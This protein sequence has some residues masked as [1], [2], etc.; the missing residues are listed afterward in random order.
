MATPLTS[1][2]GE[3]IYLDT[4]LPLDA[5]LCRDATRGM[6]ESGKQRFAL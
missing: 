3:A 1:F 2:S 5:L 6:L 4:M